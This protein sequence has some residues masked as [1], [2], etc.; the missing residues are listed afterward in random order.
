[1]LFGSPVYIKF[2]RIFSHYIGYG[3]LCSSRLWWW[4]KKWTVWERWFTC[5]VVHAVRNDK[6][7][8]SYESTSPTL[9][10]QGTGPYPVHLSPYFFKNPFY[11]FSKQSLS[12][13]FH[14][15]NNATSTVFRTE[16]LPVSNFNCSAEWRHDLWKGQDVAGSGSG[17]IQVSPRPLSGR[18][19]KNCERSRAQI[20]TRDL[21]NK[22]STYVNRSRE[23]NN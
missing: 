18:T 13:T 6:M 1:M 2:S 7:F 17:L 12:F 22:K 19:G 9:I 15:Q 16:H 4:Y 5:E 3:I 21:S 14:D 20:W 8:C 10:Q 23:N 11:N